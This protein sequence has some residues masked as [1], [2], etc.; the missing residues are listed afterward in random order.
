MFEN[1]VSILVY[2]YDNPSG[3]VIVIGK[4]APVNDKRIKRSSHE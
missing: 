1:L 4:V 3:Y 2:Q